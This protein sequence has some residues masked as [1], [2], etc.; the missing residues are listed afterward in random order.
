MAVSRKIHVLLMIC[1][2]Y[3]RKAVWNKNKKE[4]LLVQLD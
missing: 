2:Y 1:P 4:I 3:A